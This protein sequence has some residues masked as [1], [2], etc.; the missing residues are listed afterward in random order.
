MRLWVKLAIGASL[1]LGL[2]STA[3]FA[4]RQRKPQRAQPPKFTGQEFAGTFFEDVGSVL[5]GPRPSPGVDP[6]LLRA[7]LVTMGGPS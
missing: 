1:M 3:L 5:Q 7:P 4:Q 6:M 2:G